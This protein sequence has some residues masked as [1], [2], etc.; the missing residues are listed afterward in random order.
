MS[1]ST[2]KW[3]NKGKWAKSYFGPLETEPSGATTVDSKDGIPPRAATSR[4]HRCHCSIR[5]PVVTATGRFDTTVLVRHLEHAG[6]TNQTKEDLERFGDVPLCTAGPLRYEEDCSEETANKARNP[7]ENGVEDDDRRMVHELLMTAA[8]SRSSCRCELVLIGIDNPKTPQNVGSVLRGMGVYEDGAV[9]LYTGHRYDHAKKYYT[10]DPRDATKG[11]V[12]MRHVKDWS[13]VLDALR[14][15][16]ATTRTRQVERSSG[17]DSVTAAVTTST[18]SSSSR[19]RERDCSTTM[20]SD[21]VE[22]VPSLSSATAAAPRSTVSVVAVD[23][24]DAAVPLHSF[25]HPCNTL[26]APRGSGAG[27]VGY[28]HP[29][30]GEDATNASFTSTSASSAWQPTSPSVHVV[31][32]LLGPED[33]TLP[34]HVVQQCDSV[35]FVPTVGSMN[36]AA[37]ANVLLYD[38]QV[39]RLSSF[40]SSSSSGSFAKDPSKATEGDHDG[41]TTNGGSTSAEGSAMEK[42]EKEQQQKPSVLTLAEWWRLYW[43]TQGRKNENNHQ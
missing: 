18:S 38:R 39:K 33:G 17:S 32:Y 34:Q 19:K 11:A 24:I 4:C 30:R 5:V 6:Q 2:R 16:P 40:S 10:T 22:G 42:E 8:A 41:T 43:G 28:H 3:G 7:Q 1:L 25:S 9:L 14:T 26:Q 37:T 35:V 27:S 20:L 13:V 31:L 21:T 15:H 23:M 36:L 12:S 29:P